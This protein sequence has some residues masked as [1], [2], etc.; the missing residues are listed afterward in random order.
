MSVRFGGKCEGDSFAAVRSGE[1]L[2]GFITSLRTPHI[3]RITETLAMTTFYSCCLMYKKLYFISRLTT[4]LLIQYFKF[5]F[6][7]YTI[8]F[9]R[10]NWKLIKQFC[11]Y[12][13]TSD[14]SFFCIRS[15]FFRL[16][17]R[18]AAIMWVTSVIMMMVMMMMMAPGVMTVVRG[19]WPVLRD[20]FW[21][22]HLLCGLGDR[23]ARVGAAVGLLCASYLVRLGQSRG[24][25]RRGD[26]L[27]TTNGTQQVFQPRPWTYTCKVYCGTRTSAN[28]HNLLLNLR[29]S[30]RIFAI[31]KHLIPPNV[32]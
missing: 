20:H 1:H 24:Q 29:H 7:S 23:S 13:L 6:S 5:W 11:L 16:T 28:K 31:K 12:L 2:A 26:T 17:D 14:F 9:Q 19:H 8:H 10:G 27:A 32:K 21:T 15:K 4:A 25:G 22:F 30:L 18:P 3:F